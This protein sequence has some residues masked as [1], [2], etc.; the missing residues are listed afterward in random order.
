MPGTLNSLRSYPARIRL[1]IGRA[2]EVAQW[3]ETDLRAKPMKG[4]LRDVM[5][6]AVDGDRVTYR[7]AYYVAKAETGPVIV[8]EKSNRGASTPTHVVE[9]IARR[10]ARTKEIEHG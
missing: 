4:A 10:L 3:G 1:V 7:A 5:E 6:I 9:R 2:V 8:L